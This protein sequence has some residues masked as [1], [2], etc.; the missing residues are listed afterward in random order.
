MQY[1]KSLET[2]WM[3]HIVCIISTS[4]CYFMVIDFMVI[5]KYYVLFQIA[6]VVKV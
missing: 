4:Y 2:Y 6:Y 5:S 1:K 3:H